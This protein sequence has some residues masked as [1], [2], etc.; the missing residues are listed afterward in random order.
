MIELL[1]WLANGLAVL[2]VVYFMFPLF[3]FVCVKCVVGAYY[4][5]KH[6]ISQDILKERESDVSK[7]QTR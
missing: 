1:N 5:T 2:F 7:R 6:E 4:K 3:L